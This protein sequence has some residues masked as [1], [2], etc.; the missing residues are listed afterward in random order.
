MRA[1]ARPPAPPPPPPTLTHARKQPHDHPPCGWP[2]ARECRPVCVRAGCYKGPGRRSSESVIRVNYPSQSSESIVRVGS[3]LPRA[4]AVRG[5]G[6]GGLRRGGHR[7]LG[8][9][10]AR[11]AAVA[12]PPTLDSRSKSR[13][14]ISNI[15]RKHLECISYISNISRE[16]ISNISRIYL[17]NMAG[18]RHARR[19]AVLPRHAIAPTQPPFM[20]LNL[21]NN[22]HIPQLYC[23]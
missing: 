21:H 22:H 10:H 20:R 16:H 1:L 7:P 15:S 3:A 23:T 17:V 18:P 13:M 4:Q 11:L 12:L 2:R 14:Y 8:P 5:A 9:R 19:V 6:V